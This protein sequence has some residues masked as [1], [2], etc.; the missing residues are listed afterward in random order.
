MVSLHTI[1]SFCQTSR[2]LPCPSSVVSSYVG[3]T[4]A[5]GRPWSTDAC[6]FGRDFGTGF[7]FGRGEAT[8]ALASVRARAS[9]AS[10]FRIA[11]FSWLVVEARI[12]QSTAT[13]SHS[14]SAPIAD[15]M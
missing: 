8:T 7:G 2:A 10:T 4:D 14:A 5:Y 15:S 13:A 11:A 3:V 1:H 9:A 12:C 6:D